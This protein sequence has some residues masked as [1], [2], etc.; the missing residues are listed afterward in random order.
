MKKK[1]EVLIKQPNFVAK[2]ARTFNKASIE[3][4]GKLYNRKTKHKKVETE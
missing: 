3:P 4:S 1:I 2:H